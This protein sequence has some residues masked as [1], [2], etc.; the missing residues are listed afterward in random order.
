MRFIESA[1][2]PV[3]IG[4]GSM[5]LSNPEETTQLILQA[6]EESGQRAILH[7]GWGGLG[8]NS[9][10]DTVFQIDYAAYEWLFPRMAAVIH[11]GGSGTTA[12]ALRAGVPSL[13]VP[14]LFDQFYWARRV[15]DL[16]VGPRAIPFRQLTSRRLAKQIRRAVEDPG[17]RDRA[18]R[19][20][21]KLRAENGV[22]NA[23]NIIENFLSGPAHASANAR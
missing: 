13:I 10:P 11:H 21:E 16:G 15:S 19:L 8:G 20:G 17:L 1:E 9:L 7:K 14:F 22:E 4:F 5:P 12:A 2:R 23:I 6:L 3:F 18:Q